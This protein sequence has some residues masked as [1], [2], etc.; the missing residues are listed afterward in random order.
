MGDYMK[1]LAITLILSLNTAMALAE[2]PDKALVT[3][4]ANEEKEV[5]LADSFGKTLYVFDLD[6]NTNTSKCV[7]DCA[8][9]WPPYLVTADEVKTLT[10]P[11]A[12]VV[13]ANKKIQLTYEGHPVYTYIFDRHIGDDKGDG[14]NGIWHYIEIK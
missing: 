12:S 14:L 7:A 4:V 3:K 9:I 1:N 5:L 13:R 10:P 8:E 2:G 11:L 6:Q